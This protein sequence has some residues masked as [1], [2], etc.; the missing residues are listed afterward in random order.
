LSGRYAVPEVVSCSVFGLVPSSLAGV[1]CLAGMLYQREYLVKYLDLYSLPLAGVL[2]LAG[3]LSRRSIM[4]SIWTCTFFLSRCPLSGRYAVQK[5]Y[6]VQYLD[7]YR[8]P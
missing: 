5:E 8:P 3:M 2:C 4:F 1:L 7:L 6:H